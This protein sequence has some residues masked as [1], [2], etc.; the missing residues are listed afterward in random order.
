MCSV[1][2]N[3]VAISETTK[4]Q[5][6]TL[7]IKS[8]EMACSKQQGNKFY[9]GTFVDTLFLFSYINS[10]NEFHCLNEL[11]TQDSILSI[12]IMSS[13]YVIL[14]QASGYL[15]LV[16]VNLGREL[17]SVN[18]MRVHQS[19]YINHVCGIGNGQ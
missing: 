7:D 19:G 13:D 18:Y 6:A 12:C 2:K 4:Q 10:T 3:V 5:V 17:E 11:R 15:E 14:G 1:H 8:K 16:S 9:I